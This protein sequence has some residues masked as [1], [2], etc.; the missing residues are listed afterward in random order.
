MT[1]REITEEIGALYER[2][3]SAVEGATAKGEPMSGEEKEQYAK[4]SARMNSLI[5][6][7]D[8]HYALLDAQGKAQSVRDGH[9]AAILEARNLSPA[10]ERKSSKVLDGDEYR[11]AF[12]R[13]LS[14]GMK[15][16]S[17]SEQRAMSEGTDTDGGFL[18]SVDFYA[19]LIEKRLLANALRGIS[20]Q[21]PLGTFKTDVVIES[22]YG[23]A[24]YYAEAAAV[25][26]TSPTFTNL[27]LKPYTMR[28]FT[29][30]SNE[31]IADAPSR[32]P[33]FSIESILARQIGKVMGEKEEATFAEGDG[34][35][36]PKGIFAYTSG[37]GTTISKITTAASQ[38]IAIAD[39]IKTVYALPRQYRANARWVMTDSVFA[40][41]RELLMV[42]TTQATAAGVT[43]AYAPLGWSMGDGRYQDGEPDRLL[44]Y[45]V[46]CIAQGPA[47]PTTGAKIVACF[48]DF[49]G[50]YHIGDRES[51]SIKVARETF[52][53]NN[54][55]GYFAFARHDAQA[56]VMDAFRYLE[57]KA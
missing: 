39:L 50:Y 15:D 14:V 57:I 31:L 11:A 12:V 52:L 27:I 47:F 56:S 33:A 42:Q 28:Y 5:E 13:Y 43:S 54:Q 36:K 41:L 34:S 30:I 8:Q 17:E 29:K 9:K 46:T 40:K 26:E 23:T 24:T 22:G 7:R 18:P 44:G 21:M 49:G 6:L 10:A 19:T 2:M 55:T 48:G 38:S 45:P 1:I 3:K 16:L 53:A 25:N 20:N 35:A 51:I 4:N 32:G 37:T